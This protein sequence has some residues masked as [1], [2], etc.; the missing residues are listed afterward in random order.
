MKFIKPSGFL[1]GESKVEVTDRLIS[2]NVLYFWNLIKR[3]SMS[4]FDFVRF[5]LL[6]QSATRLVRSFSA[7]KLI[8]THLKT[9][10][11]DDRLSHLG[12]LSVQ[13]RRARSLNMDYFF[14]ICQF[15]PEPQ[16]YVVL[17]I[18]RISL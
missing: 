1:R 11:A 2:L 9:T 10:M 18:S 5:I 15:S 12:I 14:T 6:H 17:N 8:K 13:S 4:Y 16:N 7:L 3:S